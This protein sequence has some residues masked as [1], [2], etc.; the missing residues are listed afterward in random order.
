MTKMSGYVEL[1][2]SSA[3]HD[4]FLESR[5]PL[6]DGS[7]K[8]F[9]PSFTNRQGYREKLLLV[10]EALQSED[11]RFEG[12]LKWIKEHDRKVDR[13]GEHGVYDN[14]F[15][16]HGIKYEKTS[17]VTKPSVF[18]DLR[19][20]SIFLK[21]KEN[22]FRE[23]GDQEEE[24]FS[25][26]IRNVNTKDF[27]RTKRSRVLRAE[28]E[29]KREFGQRLDQKKLG[30]ST[31]HKHSSKYEEFG[32]SEL[33]ELEKENFSDN[34]NRNFTTSNGFTE[35]SG[36]K[37]ELKS[38]YQNYRYESTEN[39]DRGYTDIS[40]PTIEL[41]D[42]SAINYD[43]FDERPTYSPPRLDIQED[44]AIGDTTLMEFQIMRD[45][46]L[47]HR[48]K[49]QR[50]FNIESVMNQTDLDL[51]KDDILSY[52]TLNCNLDKSSIASQMKFQKYSSKLD[53]TEDYI[54]P[55]SSTED[56][57]YAQMKQNHEMYLISDT[58]DCY[59]NFAGK[60]VSTSPER[61]VYSDSTPIRDKA[62]SS[63]LYRGV[64]RYFVPENGLPTLEEEEEYHDYSEASQ[65][66]ILDETYCHTCIY[67]ESLTQNSKSRSFQMNSKLAQ[68][69]QNHHHEDNEMNIS[70]LE[71]SRSPI[72]ATL[73]NSTVV[74]FNETR[75]ELGNGQETEVEEGDYRSNYSYGPDRR[76]FLQ[77]IS[78]GHYKGGGNFKGD[79]GFKDYL[80][81]CQDQIQVSCKILEEWDRRPLDGHAEVTVKRLDR[82]SKFFVFF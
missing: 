39:E 15:K 66:R 33:R 79:R 42:T 34:G 1:K 22:E 61:H 43:E 30:R 67:P 49:V 81:E 68:I 31:V 6:S 38:V 37:S 28:R 54:I 26:T 60:I 20:D 75:G 57:Y 7:Y 36:G 62:A 47:D 4:R 25:R 40:R 17:F 29:R 50:G 63:G 27:D 44:E 3:Y 18:K 69:I 64:D 48:R 65:S 46:L 76:A 45:N 53:N 14:E 5:Q 71:E 13:R 9:R 77:K 35:Y 58:S 80:V 12:G 74:D 72:R 2:E 52:T 11:D 16:G 23:F 10:N 24:G 70:I 8:P 21:K 19:D 56:P 32:G 41:I 59:D 82:R 51:S 73:K 55:Q 78:L